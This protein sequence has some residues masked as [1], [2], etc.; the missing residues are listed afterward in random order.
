MMQDAGTSVVGRPVSRV[1]GRAKVT[2]SATYAAELDL[3]GLAH[4]ALAHGMVAHGIITRI[5]TQ[6]AEAAP[7]VLA[8]LTHRNAPRLAYRKM[9]QRPVVDPQGGEQLHVLQG[10]EVLFVGQ[11]VALVVAETLAEAAYAAELVRVEYDPLPAT[12]RLEDAA[13]APRAPAGGKPADLKRGDA[14]G[15][16]ATA[17]VSVDATCDQPME[18]HCAIEPHVTIAA[19]DGDRL[20]LWDKTQWVGNDRKEIAHVFGMPEEKIRVVS[21][22]VGGAFG[23]GLRTW[24]HVTLAAMAARAVG[25]PVRLELTRRQ[26]FFLTGFR[27][28]TVQRV[29]IGA[30]EDGRLSAILHEVV[31]HTSVYEDYAETTVE[32]SSMLYACPNLRTGSRLAPMHISSPCPMRAPGVVT[33]VLAL[34]MAMDELAYAAGIDPLELRVRNHADRDPQKDLPW[35]SK[36]L[37]ECYRQG[38]ERFGW[39]NR[40]PDPRS[41][42]EDGILV[43]YGMATAVYPTHRS[44]ASASIVLRADGTACIYSAASDMGPG[45]YT[46]MSQVAA[47]TLGLPLEKI[48]FR[49]GDTDLPTAPVH[50]GSITMASVGS[51]VQAAGVAVRDR[52]LALARGD[53]ESPLFG[54]NTDAVTFQGGRVFRTDEPAQGEDVTAVLRRRGL[55]QVDA[56][57]EAAPGSEQEKFSMHAF[58][59]VFAE[60][61]IDP[62]SC[63]IRVPRMVGAYASGRIV[64]P[65]TA[66]SQCIGGM[67]MGLGMALMEAGEWDDRLGRVMNANLAEYLVPV[68]ADAPALDVL[69]VEEH[70]PY[71]NPLGVKGIAELAT[72]GAAPAIL[73]AVYHATGVRVRSLPATPDRLL[74]LVGY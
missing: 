49:L 52:V 33:G 22:F 47:D 65:K 6:A 67:M 31:A 59:A 32:P 61:R 74:P 57:A 63:E 3:P 4:A 26:Q 42:A 56:H 28:R 34:E 24:P 30:R 14:D 60:V 11:P 29:A 39:R 72:V 64:N 16:L 40:E 70:D 36:S 5:D 38:A 66:R 25:R 21:P 18:H 69:L 8:V 62:G 17:P 71:V 54:L 19:W 51:A 73:N 13:A 48:E 15:A 12:T 23:S 44:K 43:G 10:P 55:E 7:G 46:S 20:T 68:H 2:G 58:G 41:M 35:S 1:D 27:P 9:E 53:R 45:T 50:G 37:L